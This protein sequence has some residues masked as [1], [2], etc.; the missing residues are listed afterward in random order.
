MIIA[1][2][3]NNGIGYKNELPWPKLKYDMKRFQQ[4]TK[5]KIVVF[6]RKTWESILEIYKTKNQPLKDRTVVV[7]SST[8]TFADVINVRNLDDFDKEI[9][10]LRAD[11][12]INKIEEN[13]DIE[14]CI[15]GG[16]SIYKLFEGRYTNIHSTLIYNNFKVN[17]YYYVNHLNYIHKSP[18]IDDN[19]IIYRF[20]DSY[21]NDPININYSKELFVIN[22][23]EMQYI[24]LLSHILKKG[25]LRQDRTGVGTLSVFGGKQLTFDLKNGFPLITT[26]KMFLRGIVEELKWFLS[27]KC[28]NTNY[29]VEKNVHIWDGNSSRE[30]LDKIGLKDYEIGE[31]GPIYGFQWRRFGEKYIQ[32]NN[33]KLSEI[34]NEER[35]EGEERGDRKRNEKE[36]REKGSKK[37]YYDVDSEINSNSGG[38]DQIQDVINQIQKNPHSR[39]I[40][41]TSWN[42]SQTSKMAL[43]PCH[44]LYMFYVDGKEMNQLNCHMVMRSTDSFLG[45]PFNIASTALLTMIIAKLTDKIPRKLI[46]SFNDIHI[47]ATH[48][49]QVQEQIQREPYP[50]PQLEIKIDKL[51]EIDK[52]QYELINYKS[53]EKISGEMAS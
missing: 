47:Y 15:C 10:L 31:V 52:L 34:G 21:R 38:F 43:P 53:H 1:Q 30:Y 29:L 7:F 42:P 20:V 50:F 4:L 18:K 9:N 39:R 28:T 24:N 16:A 13:I 48:I 5:N 46:F 23:E 36:K 32:E 51:E 35:E 41:F 8:H 12:N 33:R 17:S 2:L 25:K 27:G 45:L 44:I 19:G 14:V 37:R 26:K 11:N 6:G 3:L 40:L 49:R 22:T